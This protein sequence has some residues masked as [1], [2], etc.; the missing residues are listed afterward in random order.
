[1]DPS[2]ARRALQHVARH[3]R[4]AFS[5]KDRTLPSDLLTD[6]RMTMAAGALRESSA[7][8]EAIAE[9]VGYQ[10]VAAFRR[11]FKEHTGLTPGEWRR[12]EAAKAETFEHAIEATEP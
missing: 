7:S 8:T 1:M 11:A 6:I 2:H 12:G 3:A 5:G 4:T 10:S 9:L